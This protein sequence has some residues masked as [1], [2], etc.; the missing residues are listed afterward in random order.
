[1]ESKR[2]SSLSH[3]GCAKEAPAHGN[4]RLEP[5]EDPDWRREANN[6]THTDNSFHLFDD[7]FA[8]KDMKIMALI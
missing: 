2:S 8:T 5:L 7:A 1:M 4:P 3:E 6:T